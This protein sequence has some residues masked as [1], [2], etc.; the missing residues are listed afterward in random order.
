MDLL[1]R[2]RRVDARHTSKG[3]VICDRFSECKAPP[4]KNDGEI[5]LVGTNHSELKQAV[6]HWALVNID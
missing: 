4:V 2:E 1:L 3:Y 6:R 5:L